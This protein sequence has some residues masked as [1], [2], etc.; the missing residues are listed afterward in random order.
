MRITLV[1]KEGKTSSVPDY[2]AYFLIILTHF[3][4]NIPDNSTFMF[5]SVQIG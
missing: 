4:L 2:A 3:H 5:C 1:Y